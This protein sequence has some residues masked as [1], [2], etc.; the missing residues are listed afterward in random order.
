MAG[1]IILVDW[2][3]RESVAA[4]TAER[5]IVVYGDNM[6]RRGLGGTAAACR[7]IRGTVGIPTKQAPARYPSAYFSDADFDRVRPYI[8]RPFA[9]LASALTQG[10]DVCWPTGGIGTHLACLQEKSPRI[11]AYL[12][13]HREQL[14]GLAAAV[15]PEAQ[16]HDAQACETSSADWRKQL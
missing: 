2:Y 1:R 13:R 16:A 8:D 6:A 5:K 15:V 7:G 9:L 10:Y 11:W 3:T 4:L 14:F 12:E